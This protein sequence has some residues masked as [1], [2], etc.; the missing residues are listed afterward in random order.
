ML[1]AI[2]YNLDGLTEATK[3]LQIPYI[4]IPKKSAWDVLNDIANF[5]C[6][7]V[8]CDRDGRVKFA[9]DNFTP[10]SR[11]KTSGVCISP[12]NAFRFSIPIKSRTVVNQVKAEYGVLEAVP[13]DEIDDDLITVKR[14]ECKVRQFSSEETH[15]T[16]RPWRV[17]T[18]VKLAKVYDVIDAVAVRGTYER[19]V[20]FRSVVASTINTLTLELESESNT[21]SEFEIEINWR[22][23]PR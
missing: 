1:E 7:Y 12:D 11:G 20:R 10:A 15:N 17:E 5:C 23:R 9:E 18:T 13:A 16:T 6:C 3:R 4:L 19:E 21:F 22:D 8:Y 14:N 2:D